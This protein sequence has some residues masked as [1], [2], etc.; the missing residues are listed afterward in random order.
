MSKQ[1]DDRARAMPVLELL[2]SAIALGFCVWAWDSGG[3]LGLIGCLCGVIASFNRRFVLNGAIAGLW[4]GI[5]LGGLF[6]G[7]IAQLL[8]FAS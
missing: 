3:V 8:E 6:G 2:I 4:V 7:G 1:A 5:I